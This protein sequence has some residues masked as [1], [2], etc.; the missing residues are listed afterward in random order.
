[1]MKI[2]KTVFLVLLFLTLAAVAALFFLKEWEVPLSPEKMKATEIVENAWLGYKRYFIEPDGRVNRPDSGDTV[3]EGQAY[4]MLRAVLTGDKETFDKCYL[5]TEENLSRKSSRG[6]NLL[7]WLWDRGAVKD[8]MP[9][10]DAD[11]DYALALVFADSIWEGENP[12]G[13]DYYGRRARYMLDDILRLLT[14][15]TSS[16]RLYLSP[17][18]IGQEKKTRYPVNPSYYSPA[19]F[20]VFYQFTSD[21][22]WLELVDTMYYILDSISKNFDGKEGRGLIPDWCAVGDND[23]FYVLEGKSSGFGW[24]AVRVPLRVAMDYYWFKGKTAQDFLSGGFS[25]F[26]E[27]QW[28]NNGAVFCEYSYDGTSSNEYEDALFYAAYYCAL[29]AGESRYSKD[30]LQKNRSFLRKEA[31]GWVYND[32]SAYYT[33]SLAWFADGFISGILR[34]IERR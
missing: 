19:H 24:E 5:W 31:A 18:I 2:K 33:N 26:V 29:S 15:R 23:E 27:G 9:A 3:S 14:Y 28:K 6:D 30:M 20:R 13:T 1:M 25:R 12:G 22:R 10:A 21:K 4:A 34:L 16:G 32:T 11:I 7:A 17:W 8:W